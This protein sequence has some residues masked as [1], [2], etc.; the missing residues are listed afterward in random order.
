LT[1]FNL[2][3]FNELVLIVIPTIACHVWSTNEHCIQ[4]YK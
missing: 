1:N 4:I 2:V 3:K